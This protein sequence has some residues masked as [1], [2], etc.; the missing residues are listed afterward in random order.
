MQPSFNSSE[1]LGQ[2]IAKRMPTPPDVL[3][4]YTSPA[5]LI[6][7]IETRQIWA[8]DINYLNDAHEFWHALEIASQALTA[9][10]SQVCDEATR[11]AL[12]QM[13]ER[14]ERVSNE[15]IYVASFSEEADLL[16]QWR[17]Y[18]PPKGG[19]SIGFPSEVILSARSHGR[20]ISVH[21]CIYGQQE[22]RQFI[23]DAISWSLEP[24]PY[25]IKRSHGDAEGAGHSCAWTFYRLMALISPILKDSG[26]SEEKEWRLVHVTHSE[27]PEFR[28]T[29]SMLVP[30]IPLQLYTRENA[31]EIRKVVVGPTAKLGLSFESLRSF[32]SHAGISCTVAATKL[33]YR[34]W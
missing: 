15:R 8:T 34:N 19:F 10:E 11:F 25:V 31:F 3:Y 12:T 9:R 17:A 28:A 18:C 4:H 14:L 6:G 23:E 30:Y 1:T 26:F 33:P 27:T 32:L 22:Q 2:F 7:I 16:S 13:K 21:K 5:G 20:D 24:L 29:D